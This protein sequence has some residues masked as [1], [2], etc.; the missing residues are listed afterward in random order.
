MNEISGIFYDDP[1]CFPSNTQEIAVFIFLQASSK[2]LPSGLMGDFSSVCNPGSVF[3]N[4]NHFSID[5]ERCFSSH[6][7]SPAKGVR[8]VPG[9]PSGLPSALLPGLPRN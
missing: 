3:G 2:K 8:V 6:F 7:C 9:P 4:D 5:K 1:F